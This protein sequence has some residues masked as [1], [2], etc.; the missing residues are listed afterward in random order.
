VIFAEHMEAEVLEKVPHRHLVLSLP[1]RLRA[2][3]RYDRRLLSILFT[4]AWQSIKELFCAVLPGATP[5]AVLCVQSHGDSL[6]YNPHLHGIVTDGAFLPDGTWQPLGVANPEKLQTLFMH[7][8][9]AELKAK[10]L[11]DD[12]TIEQ[13]L[14]QTH[15]GFSAWWGE[16]IPPDDAA[17]R[18]FLSRYIDRGPVAESRISITDDI[19][20]Y[21]TPKDDITHEFEP[22]EFLARLTPHIANRWE[23]TTRYFGWYS[24]RARGKRNKL[25]IVSSVSTAQPL[26][27]R[28]ASK[29]WAAL[30]KR[31]FEVDPLVCPKCQGSMRIREFLTD[32]SEIKAALKFMELSGFVQPEWVRGPPQ[33][34]SFEPDQEYLEYLASL[35]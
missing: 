7:R 11:I 12:T 33:T 10:E 3:F 28:K 27:K 2:F 32:Q 29:R 17:Q 16:P 6:N 23:S 14:A 22:L 4:A 26:Q 15:S 18:L 19:I 34:K 25:K 20:T 21:L 31:V 5:G 9:L 13:S 35:N 24:S 30:I 1:K 8:V